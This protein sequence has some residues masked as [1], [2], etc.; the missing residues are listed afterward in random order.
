MPSQP[1]ALRS[2]LISSHALLV[3]PSC[4]FF[5]GFLTK[6]YVHS[7]FLYMCCMPRPSL[8]HLIFL[9]IYAEQYSSVSSALYTFLQHL[10]MNG[11]GPEYLGFSNGVSHGAGCCFCFYHYIPTSS[12][13]PLQTSCPLGVGKRILCWGARNWPLC[14]M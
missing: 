14:S 13:P 12:A 3:L 5:S 6:L 11:C 9:T 7:V 10:V 4:C 2:I 8:L 1:F